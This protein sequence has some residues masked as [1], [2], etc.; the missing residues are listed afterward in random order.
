MSHPVC[1]FVLR[2]IAKNICTACSRTSYKIVP[3]TN[4]NKYLSNGKSEIKV[5]INNSEKTLKNT[6]A[7]GV[8]ITAEYSS[9]V[10]FYISCACLS[11]RPEFNSG[12]LDKEV[13][14]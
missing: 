12:L 3:L 2:F 7:I 5:N 13:G 9:V 6:V 8:L 1:L 14:V 11:G 10:H 4:L